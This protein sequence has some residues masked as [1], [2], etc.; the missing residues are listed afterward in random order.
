MRL[1]LLFAFVQE[2]YAIELVHRLREF[3][4]QI[5]DFIEDRQRTL[6][7]LS[8]MF[9]TFEKCSVVIRYSV[10]ATFTSADQLA[11]VVSTGQLLELP[12]EGIDRLCSLLQHG[13]FI[14]L[15]NRSL[16]EPLVLLLV[17]S[18]RG[19]LDGLLH[20]T[21]VLLEPL[22]QVRGGHVELV[23]FDDQSIEGVAQSVAHVSDLN[24][25]DNDC[26]ESLQAFDCLARNELASASLTYLC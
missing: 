2:Q 21:A 24:R 9:S 3:L 14:L 5:V 7:L 20:C 15:D 18:Q 6:A 11:A 12:R 13:Q 19:E 23:H 10:Q 4:V 26:C 1:H 17:R 25:K 16:Q 22:V 8:E